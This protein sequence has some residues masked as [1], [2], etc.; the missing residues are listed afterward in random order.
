VAH[1]TKQVNLFKESL[2]DLQ[3]LENTTADELKKMETVLQNNE[4]WL[5]YW[6]KALIEIE[7]QKKV[8]EIT[9]ET[10]HNLA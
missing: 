4:G 9:E 1:Y 10:V 7:L 3:K 8:M 2:L 6:N 5:N